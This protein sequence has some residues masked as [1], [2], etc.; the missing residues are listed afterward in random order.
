MTVIKTVSI[1]DIGKRR[2]KN[3]DGFILDDKLMLYI[4]AD[5]MGGHAAG[6]VASKIVVDTLHESIKKI[7][8]G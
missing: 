5:G 8:R 1:T 2:K 7:Q 4:V 3:E 6:E